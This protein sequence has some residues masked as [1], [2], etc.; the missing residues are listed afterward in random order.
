MAFAEAVL[1]IPKV[2]AENSGYDIQESIILLKDEYEKNKK[3]MGLD[4]YDFGVMDPYK[5]GVFDNYCVK[6]QFLSITTTLAE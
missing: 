1:T 6:R 2:L 4:L 3:P 5:E